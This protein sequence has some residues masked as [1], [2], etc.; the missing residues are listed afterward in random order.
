PTLPWFA[1]NSSISAWLNAFMSKLLAIPSLLVFGLA[2][3]G[4]VA[5]TA[6]RSLS[7]QDTRRRRTPLGRAGSRPMQHPPGTP[8]RCD[9]AFMIWRRASHLPV[10]VHFR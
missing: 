2:G 10:H 7:Y 6:D 8:S 3:P 9:V 1:R 5:P 4:P